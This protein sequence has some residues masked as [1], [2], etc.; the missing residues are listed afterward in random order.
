[1]VAAFKASGAA[2]ACL[3]SSDEVYAH[4]AEAAAAALR[5]ARAKHI[6]FAGRPGERE[7]AFTSA[8]IGSFI[9]VGC[10]VLAM[11]KAAHAVLEIPEVPPGSAS[12]AEE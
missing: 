5:E 10:D 6:Y 3:C 12:D 9:Y 2:L 1:M 11:L 8:G 7:A 4:E